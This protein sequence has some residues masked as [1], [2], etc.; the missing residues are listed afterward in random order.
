MSNLKAV[1]MTRKDLP[2]V[3]K[4]DVDVSNFPPER[5]KMMRDLILKK[6]EKRI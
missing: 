4:D 1:N 2:P 5:Q 6:V 3:K